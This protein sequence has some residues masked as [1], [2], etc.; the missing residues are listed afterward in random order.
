MGDIHGAYKAMLQCFERSGFDC[1]RDRL[2]QLGD[3]ADGHPGV[4]QCVEELLKIENLIAIKGNHDGWFM[5]F[6]ETDFHP[7]FWQYGGRGTI[8]SYLEHKDGKRVCFSSGSGFKTSLDASDIPLSHRQFFRNQKL[9]YLTED[10]HC[11]VHGGFDRHTDFRKQKERSY[12]W[13]RTLWT[14][15][16]NCL[17]NERCENNF[18]MVTPFKKIYIGHTPTTNLGIDKPMTAFNIINLDTGAGGSSGKLTIM[19]IGTG[20]YWQSDPVDTLY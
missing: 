3:I 8:L 19:D 4:F 17:E 15:A 9:F 6:I 7:R 10:Q 13:D 1:K 5:E 14:D 12:Y 20:N 2:I 18:N 16:L 11:F